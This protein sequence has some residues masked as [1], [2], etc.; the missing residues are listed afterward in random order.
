[1]SKEPEINFPVGEVVCIFGLFTCKRRIENGSG[2]NR[3]KSST[4]SKAKI[5]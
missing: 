5:R 1:M 2:G 3:G 4:E